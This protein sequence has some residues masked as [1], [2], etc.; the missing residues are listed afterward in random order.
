M[1]RRALRTAA[2]QPCGYL[3]LAAY[4]QLLRPI[5]RPRPEPPTGPDS[6]MVPRRA[7]HAVT[8]L[9]LVIVLVLVLVVVVVV[10]PVV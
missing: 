9:V 1:H 3:Q 5:N 10:V 7:L 6:H 2:Q 4:G 8:V